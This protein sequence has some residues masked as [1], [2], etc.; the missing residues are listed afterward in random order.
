MPFVDIAQLPTGER[1]PGWRDRTFSTAAMTFAHFTFDA[2]S[3]IHEHCHL[4]EEVW[5]VIEGQL[6]VSVGADRLLAG[7]GCVAVVPPYTAHSV[8]AVTDG[9]AI[10]TDCPVRIDPSGGRRAIIQIRFDDPVPLRLHN[11]AALPHQPEA[12]SADPAG[13]II[14]PFTIHNRGKTSGFIREFKIDCK[15]APTLPSATTTEIPTGDLPLHSIVEPDQHQPGTISHPAPTTVE[16]ERLRTRVSLFYVKGVIFYDDGFGCRQHSTFC[17]VFDQ[18]AFD[19]QGGFI[20]PDS[21]G[22]NYGT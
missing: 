16:L 13:A 8:R 12:P 22:Y 21:P 15:I 14:V 1:L 3:S 20:P 4:N 9:K 10:V 19:G 5:T 6:E 7:P 2:G 11:P 18:G 17:R